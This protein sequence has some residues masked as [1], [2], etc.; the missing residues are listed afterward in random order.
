MMA[1]FSSSPG[2]PV[3]KKANA[4]PLELA[5]AFSNREN[6]VYSERSCLNSWLI[7]YPLLTADASGVRLSGYPQ[8][9]LSTNIH[10]NGKK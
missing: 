5:F 7:Q 2:I 8:R 1:R 3:T 6:P 9:I 4:R 10:K